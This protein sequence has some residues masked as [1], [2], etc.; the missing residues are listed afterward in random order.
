MRALTRPE[1]QVLAEMSGNGPPIIAEPGH[2]TILDSLVPCGRVRRY[3]TMS[4]QEGYAITD[5]G[6]LALRVCP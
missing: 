3:I 4:A 5:L 6:L 2:L 1:R